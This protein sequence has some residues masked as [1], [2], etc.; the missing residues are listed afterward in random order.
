MRRDQD[1]STKNSEMNCVRLNN[2][3]YLVQTCILKGNLS[4]STKYIPRIHSIGMIVQSLCNQ[5]SPG[6]S[7]EIRHN[8]NLE[9][10]H[11]KKAS[12]NFL[13][14]QC[15]RYKENFHSRGLMKKGEGIDLVIL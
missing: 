11:L 6:T 10:S 5:R 2:I 15:L 3:R 4:Y 7:L 13:S 12:S 14:M 1:W 9:A 8:N